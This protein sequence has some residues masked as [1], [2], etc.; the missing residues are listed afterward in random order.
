MKARNTRMVLPACLLGVSC[1]PV[2]GMVQAEDEGISLDLRYRV[3]SVSDEAFAEDA[4]AATLR[5]RLG[6]RSGE[7]LGWQAYIEF[8]DVR[9]LGATDFNSTTNGKT[10]YPVVA[11]PKDTELNQAYVSHALAD[12]RFVLGRQRINLANQRFFG[13]VG[14]RQN[15]QTYDA[16]LLELPVAGGRLQ[17]AYIDRVNRIFGAHHPNPA[18]ADT[19][20]QTAFVDYERAF[21]GVT[22][23]AYV[24]LIEFD[25]ATAASHSNLGLRV[26][27]KPGAFDW[28]LEYTTQ[29]D[30]ADGADTIDADYLRGDIGYRH[31]NFHIGVYHE[32]LGSDGVYAFQTPFATLHA[33]NGAADK[34]LTTPVN[35]LADTALNLDGSM[36]AW[37]FGFVYHQYD[38][39]EGSADY[40]T[41]YGLFAARK[42]AERW[43]FRAEIADYSAEAYSTDTT[44]LWFTL[45]A[46]Y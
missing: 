15:E 29:Q 18:S 17:A 38:A 24:H 13:A 41:E 19:Q 16:A 5:T 2:A 25:D 43:N 39:D 33:F 10:E 4:L 7:L 11:D 20:T 12:G 6:Y 3:E 40:G 37:K 27:G 45:Q 35:G 26:S 31:K 34:F 28:R 21:G 36:G 14:F 23:A 1:L 22:G 44:K 8:E 42:F 46:A 9:P 32:V 30:Y